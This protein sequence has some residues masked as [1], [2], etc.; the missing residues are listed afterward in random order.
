MEEESGALMY[1]GGGVGWYDRQVLG[2]H[3]WTPT[4]HFLYGVMSTDYTADKTV[5]DFLWGGRLE[6]EG[7]GS[8]TGSYR[9]LVAAAPTN[10]PRYFTTLRDHFH[11][12]DDNW[13][14]YEKN[15]KDE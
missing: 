9:C 5:R 15:K 3:V 11:V 12:A 10:R 4:L 6:D 7:L 1:R 8:G 2:D 13:Y 14:K